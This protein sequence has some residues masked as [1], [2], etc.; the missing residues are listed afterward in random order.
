MSGSVVEIVVVSSNLNSLHPGKN[1]PQMMKSITTM[2]SSSSRQFQKH[3]LRIALPDRHG[4]VRAD[5]RQPELP[6]AQVN[7]S[8]TVRKNHPPAIESRLFQLKS[9]APN[10]SSS[11]MNF[12]QFESPMI[13]AASLRSGGTDFTDE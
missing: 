9:T 7:A 12:S 10:G 6:V 8:Q 2:I 11:R 13:V 1:R 5:A 4:H 3:G